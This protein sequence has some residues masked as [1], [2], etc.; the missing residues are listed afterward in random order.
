MTSS[1]DGTVRI[2]DIMN[3]QKEGD[4]K[5]KT[6]KRLQFN[7]EVIEPLHTLADHQSNAKLVRMNSNYLVS[8]SDGDNKLIVRDWSLRPIVTVSNLGSVLNVVENTRIN[9]TNQGF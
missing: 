3:T 2:W 6:S 7:T 9:P 4:E 1:D 5:P 8:Y